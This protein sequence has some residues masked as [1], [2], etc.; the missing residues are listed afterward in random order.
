MS[1]VPYILINKYA[2]TYIHLT[3]FGVFYFVITYSKR[4]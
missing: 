2:R 3:F 1:S 4:V